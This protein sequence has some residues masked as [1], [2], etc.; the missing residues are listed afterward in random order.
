[1]ARIAAGSRQAK[2]RLRT[3]VQ[4][5]AIGDVQHMVSRE[6]LESLDYGFPRHGWSVAL[7][8]IARLGSVPKPTRVAFLRL[9]IR[10]GD[11]IRQEAAN[12]LALIDGLRALLPPYRGRERILYRGQAAQTPRSR[13]YGLSWTAS[14]H[15]AEGYAKGT[16]WRYSPNGS[17]VLHALAPADAIIARIPQSE[18]RY[19]EA[20]YLV[21]RRRLHRVRVVARYSHLPFETDAQEGELAAE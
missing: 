1:M 20:E 2:Q 8:A 13:L 18:D 19:G 12:D 9:Y 16:W 15:V 21:D 6:V 17:V 7:R 14:R 5:A 10:H 3:F 11:H 4:A